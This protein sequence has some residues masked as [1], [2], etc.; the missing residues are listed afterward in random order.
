MPRFLACRRVAARAGIVSAVSLNKT[1]N[2]VVPIPLDAL[3]R[4]K[5]GREEEEEEKEISINETS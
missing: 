5:K 3:G 4:R 1:P 2:V